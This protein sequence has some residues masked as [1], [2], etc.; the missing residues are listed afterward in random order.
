MRDWLVPLAIGSGISLLASILLVEHWRGATP[1]DTT[2]S[3]A[4]V[5][6]TPAD[7]GAAALDLRR[8]LEK[9][10]LLLQAVDEED[11]ARAR[12]H[13][14]EFEQVIPV[15]PSPGL[16][17]PDVSFALLD[18]F[19]LYRVQLERALS[20]EDA[21]GAIFACNQLGDILW[22]LRVQL[23]RAPLPELGRLRYLGRDL[24]YWSEVGDEQMIRVRVRGLE[25]AWDALRPVISGGRKR[26]LVE[27]F[28][29]LLEQLRTAHAVDQYR[30]ITPEVED[31]IRQVEAYF[32]ERG[33]R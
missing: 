27:R 20:T 1:P 6:G 11:W 12:V 19:N 23:G 31:A 15:L 13:F 32:S 4:A 22:D 29:E 10:D 18:F 21:A 2:S 5:S 24:R 28:E 3:P 9:L 25:R 8:A 26:E 17:Y 33:T 16:K 30:E 14:Q 7:A